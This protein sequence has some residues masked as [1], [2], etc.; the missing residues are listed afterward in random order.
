MGTFEKHI[1]VI[2]D[3]QKTN[4]RDMVAVE[5]PL[6]IKLIFNDK[7]RKNNM[8]LSV[9]MRT[10]G[11]D[12][13]LVKGFLFAEGIISKKE[14]IT[15]VRSKGP[16]LNTI[17]V[18]L[19][20][21]VGLNQI[22]L[23]RHTITNSSC[24]VCGKSS[25]DFVGERGVYIHRPGLPCFPRLVFHDVLSALNEMQMTFK[26]TGGVHA[27][28]LFDTSGNI[29]CCREDVGRHNAMD[30]VI[31]YA[32]ENN[33]LPL[34]DYGILFSGRTSFELSQKAH[35]AGLPLTVSVGAPSSLSIELAEETGMTLLGFLNGTKYNIYTDNNRIS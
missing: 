29:H 21:H 5:E 3:G 35:M 31:G 4:V 8:T 26:D 15:S 33:L 32:L 14:D 30:K 34:K 7:G 23:E 24:G 13:E 1:A 12:D 20:D 6:E 9:T 11:N 27:A 28:A 25:I 22:D 10:P 17:E 19:A 2:R 16:G 18:N